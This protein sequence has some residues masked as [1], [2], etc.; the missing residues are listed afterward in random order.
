MAR[1]KGYY[2]VLL[3][4]GTVVTEHWLERMIACSLAEWPRS[5]G[6]SDLSRTGQ[7]ARTS[8]QAA[9][10]RIVDV[11]HDDPRGI[12]DY[13]RKRLA[14]FQGKACQVERLADFC[15]LM[16][17]EVYEVHVAPRNCGRVQLRG[18]VRPSAAAG[19]DLIMVALDVFVK[20]LHGG[21]RR[22]LPSRGL[23][24]RRR[25]A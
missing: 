18:V 8:C 17:R 6:W 5:W 9:T 15:L 20:R 16:R 23:L 11:G 24:A 19:F 25:V 12:A 14:H 7:I 4:A 13:V 22:P 21:V 3:E 1:A 2:L 10:H